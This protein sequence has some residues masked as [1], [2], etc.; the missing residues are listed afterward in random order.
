MN[1]EEILRFCSEKGLLLDKSILNLFSESDTEGVK[2]IIEKIKDYTHKRIITKSFLDENK[3]EVEKI[4]ETLPQEKQK[5]LEKLRIKL[6]LSIEISK[7]ISAETEIISKEEPHSVKIISTYP[8]LSKKLEVK[9]F[10]NYFKGRFIEMGKILQ[11]HS[12]LENLVS[13]NKISG[14]RQISTI[15]IVSDKRVTKN[16]NLLFELED[17]TGKIKAVVNQNKPELYKK[18]E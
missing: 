8:T 9:D 16:K 5:S 6:G 14:G 12:E 17:L 13:I 11:G 1:V 15:G 18:A 10:V 3:K 4:I 2:I 7:E